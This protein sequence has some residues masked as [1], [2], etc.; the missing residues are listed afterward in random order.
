MEE[1]GIRTQLRHQLL[2]RKLTD[3]HVLVEAAFSKHYLNCIG[4]E[5]AVKL[6][7]FSIIIYIFIPSFWN[8]RFPDSIITK[9]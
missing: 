3:L 7:M 4:D 8:S 2:I 6:N 5:A 9:C 1:L